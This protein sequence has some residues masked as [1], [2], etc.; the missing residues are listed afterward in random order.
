MVWLTDYTVLPAT[1]LYQPIWDYD[2]KTLGKDWA[3][4]LV[5]GTATAAALAALSTA[6]PGRTMPGTD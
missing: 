1:G 5:Y 4:H 2:A 6:Q 3:D